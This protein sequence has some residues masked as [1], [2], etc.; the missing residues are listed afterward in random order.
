MWRFY[1]S[2]SAE[3]KPSSDL[4]HQIITVFISQLNY[5]FP[6]RESLCSLLVF[7]SQTLLERT[8]KRFFYWLPKNRRRIRK[9]Q[10]MFEL[11]IKCWRMFEDKQNRF[12]LLI[13][14]RDILSWVT[15][16]AK[17][18][19]SIKAADATF[20][21]NSC[22]TIHL[23]SLSQNK[24]NRFETENYGDFSLEKEAATQL[25]MKLEM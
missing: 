18:K 17:L 19:K 4:F 20:I 3:P 7:I 21:Q 24:W 23:P 13:S 10:F 12:R 5:F 6:L 15:F 1:F 16:E 8:L 14:S 11:F 2:F 9:C 25:C 22:R